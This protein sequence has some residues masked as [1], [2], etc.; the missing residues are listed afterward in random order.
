MKPTTKQL[1]DRLRECLGC[2]PYRAKEV[3][4][5]LRTGGIFMVRKFAHDG[6][7][8]TIGGFVRLEEYNRSKELITELAK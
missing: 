6:K 8:Y 3:R 5:H 2:L 4:A 7:E 1:N